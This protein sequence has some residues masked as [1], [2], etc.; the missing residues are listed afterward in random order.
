MLTRSP[1]ELPGFSAEN[2]LSEHNLLQ[3]TSGAVLSI[4]ALRELYGALHSLPTMK[5]SL[6][7]LL[8]GSHSHSATQADSP[9]PLRARIIKP[10]NNKR[11]LSLALQGGGS[12]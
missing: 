9:A 11:R 2:L 10:K 3:T 7:D 5:R 8:T 4:P 12:F 1:G 6:H